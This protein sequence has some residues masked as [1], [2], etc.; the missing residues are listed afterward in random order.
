MKKTWCL[1]MEIKHNVGSQETYFHCSVL[2]KYYTKSV[3]RSTKSV[4]RN[5]QIS[6]KFREYKQQDFK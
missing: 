3:L 6:E 4:L 5:Q 2:E 1:M